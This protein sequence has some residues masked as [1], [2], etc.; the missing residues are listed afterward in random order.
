MHQRLAIL[1]MVLLAA[2][3]ARETADTPRF[4]LGDRA[5]LSALSGPDILAALPAFRAT[6]PWVTKTASPIAEPSDWSDACA[7]AE[8]IATDDEA[9]A[10]LTT[11]FLPVQMNDGAALVTG[12]FEPVF[13]ASASPS[14][15]HSAPVLA[16]PDDLVMVNLGAFRDDL[17]GKRIAGRV[18]NGRLVPYADRKRLE[19]N[20]PD[21]DQVLAWMDPD[22]LFFLQI[23]GSGVLRI[24]DEERRIGYAAQNG[25]LYHAI[26]KTLVQEGHI[27]LEEIT[28][29]SIRAWL[30]DAPEEEAVRVRQTNPSYVFF[31][32]RGPARDG[33]G[34]V[35]TTGIP[36]TADISV[37]VDPLWIPLGAPVWM[38][39]ETDE[40][41]LRGLYVAQDTGGAIKGADRID[42][43]TGRGDDAGAIAGRLKADVQVMVL[44]PRA[45]AERLTQTRS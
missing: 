12:Y 13:D 14:P 24:D 2:C 27:P 21:S 25:H 22:D 38:Q 23:Q 35:G 44:L 20:T 10:W 1:A 43:F 33:E 11:H 42:L 28:M 30:N 41:T 19:A 39:G 36:L 9:S 18:V 26:G 29:Q 7:A 32:D 15:E 4:I 3:T 31:T 45:A 34:P 37:A 8:G 17:A 16:R 5:L 40:N 6:C